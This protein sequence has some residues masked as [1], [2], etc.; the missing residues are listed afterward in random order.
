M[1]PET[2]ENYQIMAT[3]TKMYIVA[4]IFI[5]HVRN[6]IGQKCIQ[7][8]QENKILANIQRKLPEMRSKIV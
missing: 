4:E 2:H 8:K 3:Q 1:L 7:N 5:F 6:L